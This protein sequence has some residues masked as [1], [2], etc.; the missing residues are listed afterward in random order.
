LLERAWQAAG[1]LPA[2]ILNHYRKPRVLGLDLLRITASLGIIFHHGNFTRAFGRNW[3]SSVIGGDGYLAVDM[4]LVL[5]G[6]LLT[7]QVLRMR[8]TFKSPLAFT[9]RFWTRRW[10]RTI[11]PYWVVLLLLF[12]FG[13]SVDLG[14]VP[15]PMSVGILLRHA[16]FL[17]TVIPPNAYSV[18][19]SLVTEEWFYLLLP[20][21][22][23][24]LAATVRS[25]RWV[26]GLG[27]VVLF[28]P[29]AVRAVMLAT[30]VDWL[31]VRIQPEAR[32]D[33]LVVGAL[34]AAASMGA[35]WWGKTVMARRLQL[36]AVGLVLVTAVLAIGVADS[37]PYRVVGLLAFNVCL[38]LLIP[39]LSEF[40]WPAAA[41]AWAVM[42]IA[43][44]AELT[45]PLYLLHVFRFHLGQAR[46][47]MV[48]AAAALSVSTLL[49]AATV[50]HLGVERPFLALRDRQDRKRAGRVRMAGRPD[51]AQMWKEPSSDVR[52]A[53][54]VGVRPSHA[55][56][57]G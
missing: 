49:L 47:V 44:L 15:K 52:G 17:Q 10:A 43:Y 56:R 23:L 4:F 8:T 3:F 9:V 25:W 55:A 36:F 21:V 37:W 50:L 12:I 18:S 2:V 32:F 40:H 39:F 45:Y 53:P 57:G 24:L 28:V 54:Q 46:G 16:F 14:P 22:V 33:G 34:L 20:F 41:P 51:A 29:A 26:M 35:P 6:W 19:W 27:L 11:P 38:G 30:H 48:I 31:S 1:R 7:R 5:S 42:G 13:I